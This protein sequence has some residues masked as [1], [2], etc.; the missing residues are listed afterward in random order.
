MDK[1]ILDLYLINKIQQRRQLA[2]LAVLL[3]CEKKRKMIN[4]RK[5]RIENGC[6]KD[7]REEE[8]YT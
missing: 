6:K 3:N 2:T 1:Y 8:C 4:A 7:M 5:Y